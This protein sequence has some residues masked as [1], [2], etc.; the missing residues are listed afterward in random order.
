MKQFLSCL[1][2]ILGIAFASPLFA[3]Q[4]ISGPKLKPA[5]PPISCLDFFKGTKQFTFTGIYMKLGLPED[6]EMD[7]SPTGKGFNMEMSRGFADGFG[8]LSHFMYLGLNVPFK[9]P[10]TNADKDNPAS[11]MA[12]GATMVIDLVKGEKRDIAGEI[13]AKRPTVALFAGF[14]FNGTQFSMDNFANS[15]YKFSVNTMEGSLPLGLVA[16]IPLGYYIA[17]VPFGRFAW[18]S[19]TVTTT[20]PW[21]LILYTPPYYMW[22]SG[23]PY[24]STYTST[25]LDYGMDID[26]RPFRNAPD[27][28]ISVG[29]VLSQIEGLAEGNLMVTVSI[30]KE[31]SKHYSSTTFGPKLH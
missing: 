29:T 15:G 9:D 21:M 26:L 19:T 16:D 27:W 18:S 11:A 1:V 30:K 17:L 14:D 3:Q 13:I 23:I 7:E 5:P 31:W 6:S 24:D 28:K 22:L 4:D 10:L 8:L 20:M 12:L 25:R 2:L